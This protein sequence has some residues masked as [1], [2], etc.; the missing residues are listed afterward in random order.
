MIGAG[1]L[2]TSLAL[3]VAWKCAARSAAA[4]TSSD[5]NA[6]GAAVTSTVFFVVVGSAPVMSRTTMRDAAL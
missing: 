1:G 5:E 6:V 4:V 2:L 3:P